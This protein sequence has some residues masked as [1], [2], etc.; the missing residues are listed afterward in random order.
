[1]IPESLSTPI[2]TRTMEST[3]RNALAS[4]FMVL[5]SGVAAQPDIRL[6]EK[7]DSGWQWPVNH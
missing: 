3:C 4:P 1:M 6:P 5:A 7:H 2:T